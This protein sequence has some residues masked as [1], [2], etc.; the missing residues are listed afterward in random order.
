M[1]AGIKAVPFRILERAA[2][3]FDCTINEL[4]G[5][6]GFAGSKAV[7]TDERVAALNQA[8]V[9]KNA[10]IRELEDQVLD[11]MEQVDTLTKEVEKDNSLRQENEKLKKYLFE[12]WLSE[13]MK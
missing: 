6:D 11:L 7:D 2:E 8:I 10:R 1:L 9:Q 13:V 4:I 5:D 12:K 3:I